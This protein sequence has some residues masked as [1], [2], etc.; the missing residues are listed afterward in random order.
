MKVRKKFSIDFIGALQ[1]GVNLLA[2]EMSTLSFFSKRF[3]KDFVCQSR[4]FFS[5]TQQ[6]CKW[7]W[8]PHGS[9]KKA[10]MDRNPRSLDDI[11]HF[12]RR[13]NVSHFQNVGNCPIGNS[14]K[15][16]IDIHKTYIF[17]LQPTY[18]TAHV[19]FGARFDPPGDSLIEFTNQNEHQLIES[20]G[21]LLL[22][23]LSNP[24]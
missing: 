4:R 1:Q 23:G 18:E 11:Y 6:I 24:L 16:N 12:Y 13:V 7:L 20:M 17:L 15:G 22:L 14:G 10:E 8:G 2:L 19:R 9:S 5:P 3:S 21:K